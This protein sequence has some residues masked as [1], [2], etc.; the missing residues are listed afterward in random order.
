MLKSQNCCFSQ[1]H[2]AL[3]Q[4]KDPRAWARFLQIKTNRAVDQSS[5]AHQAARMA[6]HY[7]CCHYHYHRVLLS[8]LVV[9]LL[10]C[11][12]IVIVI[13]IIIII[14]ICPPGGPRRPARRL[15][16]HKYIL[17]VSCLTIH[18]N[19][20]TYIIIYIYIYTYV[21]IYIYI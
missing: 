12:T 7:H 2:N 13:I 14:T 3:Q 11:I 16:Q 1:P 20:Y 6:Y 8:L 17:H 21:H 4:C 19:I 9:L 18:N 10:S 5:P 15:D